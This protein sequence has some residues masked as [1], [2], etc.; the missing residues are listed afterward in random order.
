MWMVCVIDCAK[1]ASKL[2]IIILCIHP[3][4]AHT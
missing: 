3:Q 1:Y 4:L 2:M